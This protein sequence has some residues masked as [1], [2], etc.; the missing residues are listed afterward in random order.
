MDRRMTRDA[1]VTEPPLATTLVLW[2]GSVSG[3]ALEQRLLVARAGGFTSISLAP[4]TIRRW[5]EAGASDV[6]IRRSL[7]AAGVRVGVVDPLTKWL[8]RWEPPPDMGAEDLA[9]GD[10]EADEVLDMARSFGADLVTAVEYTGAAPDIEEAVASFAA[11]CDQAADRGIRVGLE[12]MPFSGIREI[13][14][15]WEIVRRAGAPN[16][17]LVVDPWHVYRGPAPDRDLEVIR[18][19]PG[20]KIFTL[21]LDDGPATAE[22]DLRA[23]TMHHRLLPGD[24]AFD[25]TRFLAAV[26]ASGA[27]PV[28]GPEVMCDDLAGLDPA[29]LGRLLRS[30]ALPFLTRP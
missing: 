3:L 8:P 16:G 29:E 5:R 21:Q 7:A 22:A 12:A 25:L 4:L 1:P 27:R 24:G 30:S 6:D 19:V 26:W 14:T 11:L 20:E 28:V 15:A 2:E 13:A 17:G 9:F 23:E 10:F 18:T